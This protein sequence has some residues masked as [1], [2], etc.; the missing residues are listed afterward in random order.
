MIVNE[1]TISLATGLPLEGVKWFK[2]KS[3]DKW[4]SVQFLK[5]GHQEVNWAKGISR[6]RIKDEWCAPL[7]I[8]Q[9]YLAYATIFLYHLGL[10]LHLTGEKRINVPYFLLKSLQ[11][12][13]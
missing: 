7:F 1:K 3:V 13:S 11:K 4:Q 9:K 6:S 8:L 2:N 5:A 12:M 10:L